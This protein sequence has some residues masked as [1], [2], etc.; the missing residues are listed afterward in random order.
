MD[1]KSENKLEKHLENEKN[2]ESND[3]DDVFKRLYIAKNKNEND[4]K[5]NKNNSVKFFELINDNLLL[6]LYANDGCSLLYK[7]DWNKKMNDDETENEFKKWKVADCRV[8]RFAK[9]IKTIISFSMQ[10]PTN[11]IILIVEYFEN[12][13]TKKKTNIS[14]FKMKKT[15][16][17]KKKRCFIFNKF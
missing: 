12:E 17:K 15:S 6:I 8:I 5:L 16:I 10:K 13:I 3:S 11:D 4:A 9:N 1:N 2:N 14:L 7:I